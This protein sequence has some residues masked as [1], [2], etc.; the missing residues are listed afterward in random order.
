MLCTLKLSR[1]HT[2]PQ[3]NIGTSHPIDPCARL[4]QIQMVSTKTFPG[5]TAP[6]SGIYYLE[7]RVCP[8]HFKSSATQD[9]WG[10]TRTPIWAANI[11]ILNDYARVKTVR[12]WVAL[13]LSTVPCCCA[14]EAGAWAKG[15]A[16]GAGGCSFLGSLPGQG[17]G[18]GEAL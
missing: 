5:C 4:Q 11:V 8:R 18:G 3:P 15:T 14:A 16:H 6:V 7:V 1:Q 17:E 12:L 10:S 9:S 13:D 2:G